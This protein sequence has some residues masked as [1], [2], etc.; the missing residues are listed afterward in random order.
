MGSIRTFIAVDIAPV[1]KA[2]AKKQ[3]RV[4]ERFVSGYR[5]VDPATMH[6]TLKFLGNVPD[7]E[8][9]Q[10]CRLVE[11][12]VANHPIF[13]IGIRGVGAFPSADRAR[14]LWLGVDDYDGEFTSLQK[15]IDDVLRKEMGFQPEARDFKGHLTLGRSIEQPRFS[16]A[17]ADHL[18]ENA[19]VEFGGMEVDQVII[20]SSFQDKGGPTYTAMDTIDLPGDLQK[21]SAE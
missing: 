17:L 4:L 7:V 10:L 16:R 21:H 18:A 6:L 8:I 3:I 11:G 20:Y 14:V 2:V 12:A 9:P 15:D 13:D 1:V 19:D 5:W